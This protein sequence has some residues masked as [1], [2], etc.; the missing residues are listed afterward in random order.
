MLE[1]FDDLVTTKQYREKKLLF[2]ELMFS[3]TCNLTCRMCGS[4]FS[5][6]WNALNEYLGSLGLEDVTTNTPNITFSDWGK[7]DLSHLTKLKIMGGEPFYQKGALSLL[8]HLSDTGVLKNISLTIP[9]N[10]TVGLTERWMELLTEAKSAS[11]IL[12]VDAIGPLNDY[13]REGS[14]WSDV[15]SNIYEFHEFAST[16]SKKVKLQFNSVATAYNVNVLNEIQN[17]FSKRFQWHHYIDIAYY[18]AVLD[19]SLL[20]DHIKEKLIQKKLPEKI[21][22]YMNSKRYSTDN[23]N[24]LKYFTNALDE[25]HSKNLKDYN[26]EMYEWIFDEK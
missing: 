2:L 24:K 1:E 17:Y 3:N 25:Y 26:S 5:S 19:I 15:E 20:P 10:C 23:F 16:F 12:S 8:T 4:T 6:K 14:I 13:I 21:L 9:T 7:L 22:E 11:I 18:P